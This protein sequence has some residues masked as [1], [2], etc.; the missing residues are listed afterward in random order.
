MGPTQRHGMKI[1]CSPQSNTND[2]FLNM[3]FQ[4]LSS[5]TV[6]RKNQLN[7]ESYLVYFVLQVKNVTKLIELIMSPKNKKK[8]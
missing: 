5:R 7:S 2:F 4:S 6:Y 3:I 8:S 1:F